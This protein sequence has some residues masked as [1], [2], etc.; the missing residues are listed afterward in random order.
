MLIEQSQD[1]DLT[2]LYRRAGYLITLIHAP[3]MDEKFATAAKALRD[4]GEEEF[5]WT[6]RT[7]NARAEEIETKRITT[8]SGDTDGGV[9]NTR[10]KASDWSGNRFSSIAAWRVAKAVTETSVEVGNSIKAAGQGDLDDFQMIVAR[11]R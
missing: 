11:D 7:I 4:A 8:K 3:L 5:Q 2:E 9:E 10:T 6:V 1:P